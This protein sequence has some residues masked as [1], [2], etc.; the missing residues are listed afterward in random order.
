VSLLSSREEPSC[1]GS[2]PLLFLSLVRF[3]GLKLL[4]ETQEELY[5]LANKCVKGRVP[6]YIIVKKRKRRNAKTRKRRS[7][8]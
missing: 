3:L 4:F 7:E 2:L 6:I 8:E 1:F 5:K